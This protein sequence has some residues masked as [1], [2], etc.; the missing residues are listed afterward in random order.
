MYHTTGFTSDEIVECAPAWHAVNEAPPSLSMSGTFMP[1]PL[2]AFTPP[3]KN[4]VHY[5]A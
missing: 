1:P 2:S 3:V 5:S 4:E